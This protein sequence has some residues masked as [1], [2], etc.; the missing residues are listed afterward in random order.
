M[1]YIKLEDNI[2]NNKINNLLR[3]G[4]TFVGAFSKT[5]PHCINM[6]PQWEKFVSNVIKRKLRANIL[7]IDANVLSSIKNPLITN[8]VE[9]FPSL[10]VIKNNKFAASYNMER[11]A[12]NFL[13]FLNKYTSKSTKKHTKKLHLSGGWKYSTRKS[14]KR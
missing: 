8:N 6:Q 1:P 13:K 9:G 12:N 5:C 4:T 11:T 10:F 7:E 3:S 2:D 14:R